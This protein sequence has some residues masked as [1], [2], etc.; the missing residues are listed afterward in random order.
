MI[1]LAKLK[2]EAQRALAIM[3]PLLVLVFAAILV[4]PKVV[5]ICSTSRMAAIR[6]REAEAASRENMSQVKN[7]QR[8]LLAAWPQSRNE[9]LAFLKELNRLVAGSGV[10]LVSYR[11][12]S[13]SVG[14]NVQSAVGGGLMVKPIATEVAVVG[15]YR[16][17]VTLFDSL[18]H[19]RRLFA[20]QSLQLRTD[21]YPR[22][23]ASF[24]LVRYVTPVNVAMDPSQAL[25]ARGAGS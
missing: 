8:E 25:G 19:A 17:M 2:P 12:P 6:Q 4:V 5:G 20:V 24:R 13:A 22:L 7:G 15:C 16:D 21:T 11:P 9:Q 3:V 10:R 23:S 1:S 18:S 14:T